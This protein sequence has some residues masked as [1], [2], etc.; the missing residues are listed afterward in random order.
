MCGRARSAL[1]KAS[2]LKPASDSAWSVLDRT[3]S[4]SSISRTRIGMTSLTLQRLLG[5][6][7]GQLDGEA[8]AAAVAVGGAQ[9]AACRPHRFGGD[10]QPEAQPRAGRLA[11]DERLEQARQDV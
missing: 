6:A 11:G 5:S 3:S 9:R 2:T 4:S 1:A 7:D 10:D 8:G